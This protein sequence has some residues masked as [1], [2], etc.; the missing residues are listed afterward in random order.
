MLS[1]DVS[2]SLSYEIL[3]FAFDLSL[4]TSI[5]AKKNVRSGMPLRLMLQGELFS[6]HYWKT[7]H[8]ACVDII[9]QRGYPRLFWTLAPFEQSLQYHTTVLSTMEKERRSRQQLPVLETLHIQHVL[10]QLGWNFISSMQSTKKD[11]N[12]QLLPSRDANGSSID[13]LPVIRGEFQD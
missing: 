9:R 8:L 13:F 6:P 10:S 4:W 11:S 2:F 5:G 3:H 12:Y 1:P 7:C